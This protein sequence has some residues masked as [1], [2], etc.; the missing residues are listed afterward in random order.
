V[1][2]YAAIAVALPLTVWSIVEAV[3]ARAWGWLIS[4]VLL[5]PVGVIAWFVAGRRFYTVGLLRW[6]LRRRLRR[7]DRPHHALPGDGPVQR[8]GHAVTGVR[9]PATAPGPVCRSS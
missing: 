6:D 5:W 7:R 1:A 2:I 4:M 3:R 8:D 9:K